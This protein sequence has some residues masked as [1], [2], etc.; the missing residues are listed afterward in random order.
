MTCWF[1]NNQFYP[2]SCN[3]FPFLS[4]QIALT[5]QITDV[6]DIAPVFNKT[7]YQ[8]SVPKNATIKFIFFTLKATDED[9]VSQK[10]LTYN[11]LDTTAIP[12]GIH[13]TS[14]EL[15]VTKRLNYE[16]QSSY[17]ISCMVFDGK[18]S[19]STKVN[20][21]VTNVNDEAPK[22]D[23]LAYNLPPFEA[24]KLPP[25]PW[26]TVRQFLCFFFFFISIVSI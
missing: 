23:K 3:S 7:M 12:F 15:Y 14:G 25:S 6:N 24:G 11:I 26:A 5:V 16:K 2:L 1:S 17:L 18:F 19:S 22:F 21:T 8:A 20:I 10:S 13:A 9:F 4:E